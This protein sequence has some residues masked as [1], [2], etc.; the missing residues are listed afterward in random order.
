[1]SSKIINVNHALARLQ[2]E[3]HQQLPQSISEIRANWQRICNSEFSHDDMVSLHVLVHGL[4]GTSGTFGAMTV[5]HVVGEIESLFKQVIH[6][7]KSASSDFQQAIEEFLQQLEKE[8][9]AWQPSPVTFIPPA[10]GSFYHGN[11][12]ELVCVVEDDALVAEDIKTHLEKT[13]Y[14]VK[15]FSNPEDFI[16][17]CEGDRPDT[18]LMDMLFDNSDMDGAAAIRSLRSRNIDCPVIFISSRDDVEAR[19]A[20]TRVGA[21]R[22]FTKPV[23]TKKLDQTLDGLFSRQP[24]DPYRIL[25]VDDD[26]VL[27]DYYAT[28][29]REANMVVETL[30]DPY[31]C[32]NRLKSFNP[33]LL[34]LDVYMPG[35]TG[36][37]L[38]QTIRLDDSWASLPIVFLS[39]EPDLDQQLLALNLGGDDFFNKSVEPRHLLQA[40]FTRAKRSRWASSMHRNLQYAL[41]ES[42]YKN[43]TLDQHAIVSTADV[44]GRI[45]HANDKFCE[46]SGYSRE[47]LLGQNHRL[48]KSGRHPAAFYEEM[49][50]TI[51]HG[52]IWHGCICNRAKSGDEYWVESTIVPF[53]D[54]RGKPYQYVAARTDIT[55]VRV[56][57]DR[58]NRSQAFANIGTWDW[59]IQT[60]GLYWSER[61]APLFGYP[62]GEIEHTYENFLNSV[63]PDDRPLV[64][65]AV[66]NCVEQGK[67]Y[68]IEH[69]VLWA[70]GTVRWMHERGD[71]VR[72]EEDGKPLHMLGVVQDITLRKQAEQALQESEYRLREAQEIGQIG[73]WSWDLASGTLYWSDEIY[74]IFGYEAGAFAPN[75]DRFMAA[76][77]PGD[78]ARIKQSEQA[79]SEKG[80]KHSIDHRIILPDGQIR[81]VH[82]EA[83]PVKNDSGEV[84]CLRGTVQDISDRIW[85]EQ[86]QNGNN[87]ILELITKDSPLEEILTAIV[88][89]AE[90]MLPGVIG[91]ITLLD[92]SGRHLRIGAA[93]HLPDFYNEAMD[94][95]EIGQNVGTCCAAAYEAQPLIA[96]DLSTHP[97][98]K[99]YRDLTSKAGLRAC[100][101]L[102][103][104]ASAEGALGTCDMYYHEA[105]EPDENS[106]ELVSELAKFAAIAIEQKR[107][108]KALV[109]AKGEAE[110]ANRAKS[111][112]LSRMS[113]ELRTPMN[114]II[115]FSQLLLM[116]REKLNEIQQDN[117]GEII[118]A[119][120]HLLTLIN[121][122]LDLS[123]IEAGHIDLHIEM[124][125]VSELIGECLTT[126]TPLSDERGIAIKIMC[127]DEPSSLEKVCKKN[128]QVPADRTRLK[129]VL[130]NLLSNA[131][132]YNKDNGQIILV[133]SEKEDGYWRLSV[134]DTGAGISREQ[135]SQLFTPF[136]RLGAEDSEVEGTGIGLIITK[137]IMEL[138][139]GCIGV[140]SQPGEGS[141]F[142]IELPLAVTHSVHEN[143]SGAVP[144]VQLQA[145]AGMDHEHT[146]LC[147]EDNPA[148]LSMVSQLLTRHFS[149]HMHEASEPLLGIE[150]AVKYRPDL[151]LLDINLPVMNGF[152]VLEKLRQNEVTR[153]IPVIAIS[154]NAM[155]TDI[156]NGLE[157][158]FD[159]Y[160]TKPI[161]LDALLLAVSNEL[162]GEK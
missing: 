159:E 109:D 58:L 52:E 140:D 30:S 82:E 34:L 35:C 60:G 113:H 4:A 128:L 132:K 23:D 104:L 158:G 26:D 54:E 149:I 100:W 6:E 41:R 152:E 151:I 55:Q 136:N 57:E 56:N 36:L 9:E 114:A 118:K 91:S 146:V 144:G 33:D 3:F 153:D 47:E 155:Q 111:Q 160:I 89:H 81:W 145:D 125:D 44:A 108:L 40:V 139:G 72:S 148:N 142:W 156:D 10:T 106:I 161:N 11:G 92:E 38:A 2:A 130:F 103:I 15:H 29:L 124:V 119:G 141:T 42:E 5:C 79:A 154:A 12:N 115:G 85:N 64:T 68:D 80:E 120:K 138:M 129:Q 49:W 21:T 93:P 116:E 83:E 50:N 25:L 131:V 43:I 127:N 121:E 126:L 117:V 17:S 99:D 8:A 39:T 28:I 73:N 75:Y 98:W 59:D 77:H 66:S 150:L 27:L 110:N 13:G 1:M 74:H 70:D 69:R 133:C 102:P 24:D 65:D 45:T 143:V 157:A 19:L 61:I 112:F 90:K 62:E 97:N 96:A 84:V 76:V 135:K 37:E 78:V 101:S 51:S 14:R 122:V 7:N 87:H 48:L 18:V 162:E 147:I 16:K 94:G 88:L 53:L 107:A 22:Y 63:H 105:K 134:T 31:A 67:K 71:V 46:V 20:A 86:L 32:L 95:I 123:K 137:N